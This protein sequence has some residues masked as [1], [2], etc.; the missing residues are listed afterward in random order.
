M[1]ISRHNDRFDVRTLTS[2]LWFQLLFTFY[3]SYSLRA[4]WN[5]RNSM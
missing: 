3:Q 4:R 2:F 5:E 1:D